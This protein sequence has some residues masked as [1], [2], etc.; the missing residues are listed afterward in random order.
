MWGFSFLPFLFSSFFL[1]PLAGMGVY[2]R[3]LSM[4]AKYNNFPCVNLKLVK[5]PLH[6]TWKPHFG[7][8]KYEIERHVIIFVNLRLSLVSN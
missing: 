4:L 8:S 7:T 5:T 1:L 6:L 2:C 3:G